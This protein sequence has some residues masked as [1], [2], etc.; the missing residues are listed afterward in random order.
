MIEDCF[1]V[2]RDKQIFENEKV[3]TKN[4]NKCFGGKMY[5]IITNTNTIENKFYTEYNFL[6]L[7]FLD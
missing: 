1:K 7:I 5:L 3:N 4:I 6:E 2:K